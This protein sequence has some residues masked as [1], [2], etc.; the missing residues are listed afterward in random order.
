MP[1]PAFPWYLSYPAAFVGLGMA[2]VFN[3]WSFGYSAL[4]ALQIFLL[5]AAALWLLLGLPYMQG[6]YRK[7]RNRLRADFLRMQEEGLSEAERARIRRRA[8][9]EEEMGEGQA[10][11]SP[12]LEAEGQSFPFSEDSKAEGGGA[13]IDAGPWLS[14]MDAGERKEEGAG[15][16]KELSVF[17]APGD[18]ED[19][20]ASFLQETSVQKEG[21]VSCGILS[22]SMLR[23][24]DFLEREAPLSV[25]RA[26]VFC[27][28]EGY[29]LSEALGEINLDAEERLGRRLFQVMG[30]R[31]E[32]V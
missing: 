12:T 30:D 15:C 9:G 28:Q 18:T 11:P 23:I 3:I 29:G 6:V 17:S 7:K 21:D 4:M 31:V 14:D 1:N 25:D 13:G 26:E 27:L 16:T 8:S 32:A 5:F 22:S 10:A 20:E 2:L 24:R 19:L